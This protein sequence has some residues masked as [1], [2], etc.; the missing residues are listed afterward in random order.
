VGGA[1]HD[2]GGFAVNRGPVLIRCGIVALLLL[3]VIGVLATLLRTQPTSPA[4]GRVNDFTLTEAS[5]KPVSLADLNGKVWIASFIFTR[6]AGSCPVMTHHLARMQAELS[7]RDDLKLVSVSVDP[8]RDTPAVLA[9]YA[10]EYGADRSRWWFLTG[11]KATIRRLS[12][13]TF[14]LALDDSTDTILHSTKLVLVDRNAAIR[15]YYDGLDV[16]TLK[17]LKCDIERVLAEK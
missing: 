16:E 14:K 1:A 15:G 10:A 13:E 17:Q 12:Q 8:V 5:G 2:G 11:E 9:K 6:C 3:P 7:V 4:Y